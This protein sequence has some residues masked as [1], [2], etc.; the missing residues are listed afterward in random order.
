MIEHD[1]SEA[2]SDR[3]ADVSVMGGDN[4][5][6][7]SDACGNTDFARTL[8]AQRT[9]RH[10]SLEECGQALRLPVHL[11]RQLE[12]GDYTGIDYQVYL[13]G[14][15]R[16]YGRYLGVPD[17]MIDAELQS[18]APRQPA[19]VSTGGVSRSRYLLEHY[20]QAAS[21]IV[22]T[23][24]I[25]V[26]V[27]WFGVRGGLQKGAGWLPLDSAPVA[28]HGS[29]HGATAPDISGQVAAAASTPHNDQSDTQPLLASIAPFAAMQAEDTPAAGPAPTKTPPA[30]TSAPTPADRQP[31]GLSIALDGPSWVQVTNSDGQRLE[32][33]LL[34]SGTR[35][36]Y[37]G[38][39]AKNLS[40]RI[41][42]VAAATI[43][44]AGNTVDLTQYKHANVA[45]FDVDTRTG[46]T[47]QARN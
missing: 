39:D 21:Y 32:Y 3:Q 16:K 38:K 7:A 8:Q 28:E 44:V 30:H 42:N 23:V 31:P 12:T 29:H 13:R 11:L 46:Q 25:L 1:L 43:K 37:A 41:G 4:A 19:L 18:V 9:Q 35:K 2:E 15:L 26:P 17:A 45:H 34:P 40:V 22:L 20:A 6:P 24:V 10:L 5:L 27:L 14:Y 33:A 36:T 47:T